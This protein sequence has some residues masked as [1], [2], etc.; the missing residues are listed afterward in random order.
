MNA[1]CT[2]CDGAV[3]TPAHTEEASRSAWLGVGSIAVGTFAMVTT[4][5][6]PIGLL[7][8]IAA[9]LGTSDGTAGLM[10]TMP[11]VL[12]AFAG[13][14]LIVA[15][16]R[17][18]RRTVMIALSALLVA[19]NF[20]AALAPNFATMLVARLML[21]L[22]IGGFWT[23]APGAGTQL[24]P[25]VSKARAMSIVLAGVSGATVF[26]VPLTA[27]LGDLAGWRTAFGAT[28]VLAAA[29]LL[30]QIWLLPSMPPARAIRPRDLL[31]PLTRRMAQVGL[32]AVLFLI[33]GH[34]AA[35][36][37]LKPLLQQSFGLGPDE[38]TTLLLVYGATGFVGTFFGGSLVA[39]SVRLA[40]LAAALLLASALVLSTLVGSG[41]LAGAVVV[42]VWGAAFGLIPVALTGWMMQ[43]VPDAPEAGQ[44]LLVS[45]F[46]VAIASGALAGGVVVDG[47]GIANTML[48]SAALVLVAAA[49]IA[50][51]GRAPRALALNA[52]AE[53]S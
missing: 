5:F 49:V 3:L 50:A 16:G 42:V 28:G 43:A 1:P 52:S 17:L 2:T 41:M 22:C 6:L 21:G 39:R 24:V 27:F 29:V 32:L 18:D 20:L 7:T 26:G 12:A 53:R 9:G 36:T 44:A 13:P 45:G 51:L 46:Q 30:M 4:E 15:S 19:S 35:Y 8:D 48:M 14:A 11:G 10:V 40:A 47:Y 25:D 37:Y 33:A 23:F 31:T 38:V 34:F